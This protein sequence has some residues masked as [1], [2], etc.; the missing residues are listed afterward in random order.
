MMEKA[1]DLAGNS[2]AWW[3]SESRSTRGMYLRWRLA[4]QFVPKTGSLWYLCG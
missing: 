1:L 3:S 2:L 4:M